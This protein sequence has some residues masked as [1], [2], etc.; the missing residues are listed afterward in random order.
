M[1][2][3]RVS[4]LGLLV[5]LLAVSAAGTPASA[6]SD[7]AVSG[8]R[9]AAGV[10]SP[11][12]DGNDDKLVIRYHLSSDADLVQLRISELGAGP[13]RHV[14]RIQLGSVERGSHSWTWNG[15][16]KHG[17]VVD[18]GVY[19]VDLSYAGS[20][21]TARDRIAVDTAFA[22]ELV[23]DTGAVLAMDATPA[24]YPRSTAVRDA[25]HLSARVEHGTRRVSLTIRDARGRVV[26]RTVERNVKTDTHSYASVFDERWAARL[27]GRPL[28]PG[29][30]RAVVAGIDRAGNRGRD[31]QPIWVSKE[32]LVWHE[33]VRT[34]LPDDSVGAGAC[35][36]DGGSGCAD[37]DYYNPPCGTVTASQLFVDGLSYRSTACAEGEVGTDRASS[38][39]WL[40]LPGAPRGVVSARVQF[41]GRP[42]FAG[43]G[44][45]GTLSISATDYGQ[46]SYATSGTGSETADVEPRYGHGVPGDYTGSGD[47][48]PPGVLWGF[49]TT[50]GNAVDVQRF[51]VTAR[52]LTVAD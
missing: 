2:R 46:S 31:A 8:P 4:M 10:F 16:D 47:V 35:F 14:R 7:D 3:L 45:V 48:I 38:A 40:P 29:R 42:T 49:T 52:Y 13:S 50:G 5:P 32:R 44:D 39:H 26:L 22:P 19:N 11:N 30:Y 25:L 21:R 18:V 43:E 17:E 6:S 27:D 34:V 28:P 12:G 33:E 24:V 20:S 9:V 37:A 1:R 36:F 51:V 23:V 15:R 41:F